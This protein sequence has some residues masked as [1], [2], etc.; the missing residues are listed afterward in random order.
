MRRLALLLALFAGPAAAFPVE[1]CVNLGAALE[2]PQEGEWGYVVARPDLA[3]IAGAGFDTVRLPVR[4]DTRW[5]GTRIE[6]AFLARVDEVIGW[7]RDAGLRVIVDLHHFD[8]FAEDPDAVAPTLIAIWDALA[9]HWEGAPGDLMFEL[10]NEP[11]GA[12]DTARMATLNAEIIA[13]IRPT[14]P[15]RWVVTGGADWNAAAELDH[16]P[17][18]GPFEART[19]HYYEPW[20]FTHQQAP[21]VDEPPPPSTWGSAFDRARVNADFAAFAALDGPL[22]LGE[23]GTFSAGPEADRLDWTRTVRQA[24][25]RE[26][27]PWCYWSFSQGDI[28]GFAAVDGSGDWLAGFPDVLIPPR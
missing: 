23:F 18:P 20:S 3:L 10:V 15:T 9:Q 13:R 21:S 6:P 25:E 24:A 11:N 19:F 26:G 12:V 7:A 2:A 8:A 28:P 16:L 17:P 4:F 1:R 5:D 22:F 14:H 27:I